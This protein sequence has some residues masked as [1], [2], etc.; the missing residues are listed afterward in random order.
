MTAKRSP[1]TQL[2]SERTRKTKERETPRSP[3]ATTPGRPRAKP[4]T[5]PKQP[6]HASKTERPLHFRPVRR[7][8]AP[9]LRPLPG[10]AGAGRD[11]PQRGLVPGA[12]LEAGEE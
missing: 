7:D 4:L 2:T 1:Q 11:V 3:N 5:K 8:G 10:P 12:V 6:A 9:P